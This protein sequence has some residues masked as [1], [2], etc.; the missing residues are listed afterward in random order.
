[1]YSLIPTASKAQGKWSA[2]GE[3]SLRSSRRVAEWPLSVFMRLEVSGEWPAIKYI[4]YY[5]VRHESL[6]RVAI[7]Y[8]PY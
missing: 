8:I 5:T 7:E 4:P 3:V 2:I 6:R 1:M